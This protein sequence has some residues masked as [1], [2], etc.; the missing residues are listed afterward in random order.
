MEFNSKK[1]FEDFLNN[2]LRPDNAE[3]IY[4]MFW[5]FETDE[6]IL[7]KNCCKILGIDR[8]ELLY[9][10]DMS[11]LVDG[12]MG[13]TSVALGERF[14]TIEFDDPDDPDNPSYSTLT[15]IVFDDNNSEYI[16]VRQKIYQSAVREMIKNYDEQEYD[17]NDIL[18]IIQSIGAFNHIEKVEKQEKLAEQNSRKDDEIGKPPVR[19]P[20]GVEIGNSGEKGIGSFG[21]PLPQSAEAIQYYL[22]D[23]GVTDWKD[24]VFERI[25]SSVP[26]LG[27]LLMEIIAKEDVS[28]HRVN[29]INYLAIKLQELNEEGFAA[30]AS[31]IESGY[32][33]GHSYDSITDIINLAIISAAPQDII[34]K[35]TK[36]VIDKGTKDIVSQDNH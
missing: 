13:L 26:G 18:G 23:I 36:D 10:F 24:I 12:D 35:G 16:S 8:D 32:D 20:I 3:K 15:D 5:K 34:Y 25:V 1:Y 27:D 33:D 21:T 19:S 11:V 6:E 31:K 7:F 22:F 17:T 29:E 2:N 9:K 30:F 4:D 14:G 28:P